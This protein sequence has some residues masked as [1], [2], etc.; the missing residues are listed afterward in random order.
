MYNEYFGLEELPFSITPDPRFLY[1]SEQHREAL[2][3]LMYG[4]NSNGGFVLLTGEVGTGKTTVCRCLLEQIPENSSVAFIL[5]PK[6]TVKELLA[7]ICDEFGI[8]YDKSGTSTKTFVD[9]LN[10]YLLDTCVRGHKAVLIIDEAQN[11]SSDVL[12]QLRLLT[13]LE[14]NQHKLLQIILLG[15]PELREKLSRP[16]LR[17]LSQRILARYHLGALSKKDVGAYV[18]HR[19]AVAGLRQQLFPDST[20]DKLYRLSG[21]IPRLINIL[22]D[23]ALLGT[24]TQGKNRV[25]ISTLKKA[26]R[27]VFGEVINQ[28]RRRFVQIFAWGVSIVLLIVFGAVLAATY[29][30]ETKKSSVIN[31]A[32]D[33]LAV[34]QSY[35]NLDWPDSLPIDKSNETAFQALIHQWDLDYDPGKNG[36]ACDYAEKRGLGCLYRRGNLRSLLL[37]NRPA[38]LTLFN[39]K[40][41]EYYAAMMSV[42]RETATFTVGTETRK[43]NINDLDTYWLGDYTLMWMKPSNFKENVRPGTPN[44]LVSWID[45]Q[46]AVIQ[47]RTV[48]PRG[49]ME[50]DNDLIGHVRKFQLA[51]G[52]VPDGIVGPQTIIRLNTA[53]G[54]NVPVLIKKQ[55]DN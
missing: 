44:T 30:N 8:K 4:F 23:R 42:D 28:G 18:T 2:A 34:T 43:I 25:N 14:T 24:F 26:S 39:A 37:L 31:G 19:L 9:L 21:G 35:D 50:Y 7:T 22:C 5:N 40:G 51:E 55:E 32:E 46:L 41:Q 15:Q 38:V 13:N 3:H 10:T 1:M 17:Q 16:E 49:N 47:G 29:Y 6:L 12:E 27:E 54:A 45:K 11:L 48:Q 20:L 33:D 36:S 52:I 53:G